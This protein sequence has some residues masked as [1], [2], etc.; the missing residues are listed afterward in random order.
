MVIEE[1]RELYTSDTEAITSFA[2][3][4][5]DD[6]IELAKHHPGVFNELYYNR[7]DELT[8]FQSSIENIKTI[9][10]NFLI[11]GDAGVGKSNFIY[12]FIKYTKAVQTN[13]IYPIIVDART[14]MPVNKYGILFQFIHD[15][16]QYFQE[17]NHEIHTLMDI[18]EDN[19]LFNYQAIYRHL[20]SI[21][22]NSI[23]KHLMIILDDF[24]YAEEDW[25]DLLEYYKPFA[26][27]DKSSIV[28]TLRPQLL[29]TINDYDDRFSHY[30]VRNVSKIELQPLEVGRVLTMRIALMLATSE[31]KSL[32]TRIIERVRKNA[33]AL[34][35]IVKKMGLSNI[36]DLPQF[37]YPFSELHNI[38]MRRITNGN[39]REMFDIA[40]D[41]LI[42]LF[43]PD[44]D[45]AEREEHGVKRRVMGLEGVIR[46]VASYATCIGKAVAVCNA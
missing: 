14:S 36:D 15:I 46:I 3:I 25:F 31:K 41:S 8:F 13:S 37:E 21:D 10:R 35:T 17:I 22:K 5:F 23:D 6:L 28:F 45:I 9:A 12:K 39:M 44:N 20:Q 32:Y 4:A 42:Y 38:F 29:T 30:Y 18:T 27:T 26:A 19:L 16:Q 11:I 24:D 33:T 34:E 40:L 2:T 43:D 1:Q 7:E